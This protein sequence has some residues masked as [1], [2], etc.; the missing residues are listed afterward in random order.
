MRPD[1]GQV[2]SRQV[3]ISLARALTIWAA[4]CLLA[5]LVSV[6]RP[7]TVLA[8]GGGATARY[9]TATLIA[10]SRNAVPGQPLQLAL[11]QQIVDGWHT[12]WINPGDSGEATT[13]DWTLPAGFKADPIVW[14]TPVRFSYGPVVGYGYKTEVFLPITI[15]VP[16]DVR[17][18]TDIVLSA[19]VNWLVCSDECVPEEARLTV[20]LPVGATMEPDPRWAEAFASTANQIPIPNPFPVS[21]A[22]SGDTVT[23]HVATGDATQ[24]SD[25]AFFPRDAGVLQNDAPQA[26]AKDARGLTLTLQRD[27]TAPVPKAL[28]GVLAFRDMNADRSDTIRSIAITAPIG[29]AAAAT[30]AWEFVV[31]L[32]LAILGGLILNL[33]PCVLPV[34]SIKVVGL[35]Q[36]AHEGPGQARLH[37]LSYTGGV[38][39]SF[40][41]VAASLIALRATGSE[42]GWGFQ[43]QSPLF[44]AAM[45]YALFVVGLN[46]SGVFTL[47]TR[48]AGVG[49]SLS[50]RDGMAGSFFAGALATLVATPCT[51]PFMAAAM[52]YAITQP[53]YVSFAVFEAVGLGLALPYLAVAFSPAMRRWLP[54][55]GA[56]MVRLKEFLAFPIYGTVVWLIYVLAEQTESVGLAAVLAGLV[57]IAL[58]IWLFEVF[59]DGEG[60]RVLRFGLPAVS[61]VAAVVVAIVAVGEPSAKSTTGAALGWEAFSQKRLDAL[62]ADGRAVFV[63]FTAAW[64]I[65][66]KLNERVVLAQPSVKQALTDKNVALLRGDWTRRDAEITRVLAQ[67]G[68]AG[69]PLYLYYPGNDR[70]GVEKPVV[71]PQILT[72]DTVLKTIG[73]G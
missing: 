59:R 35:L 36:H 55:P 1:R 46:L 23:L 51:A 21:A 7:T 34:L 44:V 58:G 54:R 19:H 63:D 39:A 57:L 20:S 33:M 53:W 24:L 41:I 40:A 25:V 4:Y 28:N 43:L 15:H 30:S 6:G 27:R 37:G 31:A 45:I 9:V 60:A 62:R 17:P 73:G 47:G 14:P 12:Y 16:A 42:V 65:T 2:R 29:S 38:L 68:R 48:L 69:V 56:W 66:C 67:H 49:H 61:F 52:G 18:G 5:A 3:M 50:T 11:R 64:C 70:T 10:Q 72:L 26:V 8:Q 22:R 71:L 32:A 13:I